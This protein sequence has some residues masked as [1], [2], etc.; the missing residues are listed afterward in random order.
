[1]QI[2]AY[3]GDRVDPVSQ[4]V[5]IEGCRSKREAIRATRETSEYV[6]RVIVRGEGP[7]R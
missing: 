2:G 6:R 7:L 3:A 5:D 4:I 1:M